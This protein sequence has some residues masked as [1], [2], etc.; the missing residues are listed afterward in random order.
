MP[1]NDRCSNAR[2]DVKYCQCDCKG[3]LHRQEDEEREPAWAK[4]PMSVAMGG[5]VADFIKKYEGK[6]FAC[7]GVCRKNQIANDF[8]GYEHDGGLADATGKKWWVYV[9][10]DNTLPKNWGNR[11]CNYEVSF[12]HLPHQIEQSP[13]YHQKD[14]IVEEA[15]T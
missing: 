13:Y 4:M 8:L 9:R 11:L 10:C 2:E 1:H 12:S 5:E 15:T 14:V 6:E 7:H 3:A